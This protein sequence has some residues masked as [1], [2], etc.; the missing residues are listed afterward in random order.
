MYLLDTNVVSDLNPDK[1]GPNRGL[2]EWFRRKGDECYLSTVTLTE[3]AYGV[4]WLRHKR[5]T[6]RAARLVGWLD[7]I[8]RHHAG[9]ILPV[10]SAVA[11]EAGLLLATAR[12][13]GIEPDIADAWIGATGK[14][15]GLEVLTFNLADF[16][17]MGIACRDPVVDPPPG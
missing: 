16:R 2:V 1:A 12:A 8:I 13:G 9:R 7:Q 3:V 6:A 5:A 17:P 11:L 10:D 14:V 15:H 4:A